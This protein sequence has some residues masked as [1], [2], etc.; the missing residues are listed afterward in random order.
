MIVGFDVY[1]SGKGK[2]AVS[3]G[4][5]VATTNDTFSQFYSAV[6]HH[7]NKDMLSTNMCAD[8]T[9][10]A[11]VLFI[12]LICTLCFQC[13]FSIGLFFLKFSEC[14]CAFQKKSGELPDRIIMYRDGIGQGDL[15]CVHRTEVKQIEESIQGTHHGVKE[16]GF[17]FIV[18]TKKGNV[19]IMSMERGNYGNPR[20][21]TVVDS[22]ITLPER[23]GNILIAFLLSF[24][25]I[26]TLILN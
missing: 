3:V 11:S 17:T 23:F 21:G 15:L 4:A 7:S 9:S 22:V 19:S 24:F 10:K 1:H 20:P 5:M 8:F 14:L 25:F 16:V 2:Q 26:V 6:S 13:F 12:G 18:V